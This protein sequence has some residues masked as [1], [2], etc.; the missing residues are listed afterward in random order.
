MQLAQQQAAEPSD[1]TNP[2][3]DDK[4]WDMEA[5]VLET[6]AGQLEDGG[7]GGGGWHAASER[8]E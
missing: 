1:I 7:G 2:F 8:R 4:E 3:L 5:M 6:I